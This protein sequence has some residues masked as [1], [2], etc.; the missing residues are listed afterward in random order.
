MPFYI[1]NIKLLRWDKC[2]KKVFKKYTVLTITHKVSIMKI[3]LYDHNAILKNKTRVSDI[4]TS[5]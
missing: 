5:L 2:I 4:I 3:G 1:A